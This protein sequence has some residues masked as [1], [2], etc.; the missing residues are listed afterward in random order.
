MSK[1]LALPGAVLLLAA[2]F[3]PVA[4][5]AQRYGDDAPRYAQSYRGGYVQPGYDRRGYDPRDGAANRGYDRAGYRD[6]RCSSGT[7]GT[8]IGAIAGGLLGRS[9]DTGGDRALGTVLGAGAGALA[10]NAIGRSGN[11]PYCRR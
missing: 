2:V 4:A 8:I 10:G 6:V 11:S 1:T 5:T 7:G 3:A 9:I